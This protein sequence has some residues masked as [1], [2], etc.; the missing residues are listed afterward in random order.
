MSGDSDSYDKIGLA[1]RLAK[2]G[3]LRDILAEAAP[4]GMLEPVVL[5]LGY[6]VKCDLLYAFYPLMAA[7]GIGMMGAG[8]Y[9]ADHKRLNTAAMLTLLL[10]VLLL[11]TNGDYLLSSFYVMAHGPV[12]VYTAMLIMFIVLKEQI[13]IPFWGY[14]AV[15]SGSMILLT[16]V[17]GTIYVVLILT[18]A[19]LFTRI[20]SQIRNV[21]I[22][23]ACIAA[24]WHIA[25]FIFIGNAGDI[26]FWTPTKGIIC[27]VGVAAMSVVS[28]LMNVKGKFMDFVRKYYFALAVAV[29]CFGLVFAAVFLQ[30]DMASRMISIYLAHFSNSADNETNAAAFWIFLII[31]IPVLAMAKERVSQFAFVSIFGYLVLIFAMVLFRDGFLIHLG[32]GDSARRTIVQIMPGAVWLAAEGIAVCTGTKGSMEKADEEKG[33]M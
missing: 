9:Y 26:Y 21:N 30:R 8:L 20:S 23:T 19:L 29:L 27:I 28:L 33:N 13:D 11:L 22:I 5:S 31:L 15:V 2:Y 25:Q 32:Y 1:Y 12:A 6:M 16:R 3:T 24:V 7:S 14:A 17:E 18:A 10:G 4:Y